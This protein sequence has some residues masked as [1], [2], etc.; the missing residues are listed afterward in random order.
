[1]VVATFGHRL[2]STAGNLATDIAVAG[3]T[4]GNLA[5]SRLATAVS[6]RMAAI[7]DQHILG[8]ATVGITD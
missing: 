6:A 8:I 3:D 1:M 2:E 5:A 4:A 7:V